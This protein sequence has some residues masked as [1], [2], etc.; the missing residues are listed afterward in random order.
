M[1][2][3]K[4]MRQIKVLLYTMTYVFVI[5]DSKCFQ[6]VSLNALP[7]YFFVNSVVFSCFTCDGLQ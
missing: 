6:S 5:F 1:S 4:V 7:L 3:V 2:T